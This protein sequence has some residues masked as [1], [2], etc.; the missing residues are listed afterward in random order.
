MLTTVLLVA[1]DDRAVSIFESINL[2]LVCR[3]LANVKRMQTLIDETYQ[4]IERLVMDEARS[5]LKI[6]EV[7]EI[8][9]RLEKHAIEHLKTTLEN[10][11]GVAKL[12][13]VDE[14]QT[15]TGIVGLMN[16]RRRSGIRVG[17]NRECRRLDDGVDESILQGI[18]D[19]QPRRWWQKG[20]E[21]VR[22]YGRI[23]EAAAVERALREMMANA[24]YFG[25]V[26]AVEVL[27]SAL[28]KPK[29]K[30][31]TMKTAMASGEE[32]D[33]ENRWGP[34]E[35]HRAQLTA[36]AMAGVA[37]R[38]PRGGRAVAEV[39]GPSGE[40]GVED[41]GSNGP[42]DVTEGC[43]VEELG[44]RLV[45]GWRR[46]GTES[47]VRDTMFQALSRAAEVWNDGMV[48]WMMAACHECKRS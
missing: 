24:A 31:E 27:M 1:V 3:M 43:D 39:Q 44:E 23:G 17:Q 30:D 22:K 15:V 13:K 41:E 48:E 34:E 19:G 2:L 40:R 26:A 18:I 47:A 32:G 16:D 5:E 25:D 33:E 37:E 45:A 8:Q 10:E 9:D 38:R 46:Q 21:D 14:M 35:N 20:N 6:D 36:A 12:M 29:Q 4:R 42:K 28:Q 7:V 11:E